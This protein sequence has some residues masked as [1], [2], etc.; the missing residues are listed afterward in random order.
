[1]CNKDVDGRDRPGHDSREHGLTM[2][3]LSAPELVELIHRERGCGGE[4]DTGRFR[5][6]H[7]SGHRP[8]IIRQV[9]DHQEIDTA[10]RRVGCLQLAAVLLEERFCVLGALGADTLETLSRI[11]PEQKIHCHDDISGLRRNVAGGIIVQRGRRRTPHPR[12]HARPC[13]GHP[14]LW[15]CKQVRRGWPG[16]RRAK[17][18]RSSNGYAR[19]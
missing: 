2:T 18:R 1:M 17:A 4:G 13:A 10:E 5:E 9:G 7:R 3:S 19:P 8:R 12:R 6:R 15:M 16:H 11:F 14:R